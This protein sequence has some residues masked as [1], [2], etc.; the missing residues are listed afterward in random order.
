MP[1]SAAGIVTGT[2]RAPLVVRG[3]KG[4]TGP[5]RRRSFDWAPGIDYQPGDLAVHAGVL[6]RCNTSHTSA[7]TFTPTYFDAL[8]G[9]AGPGG[10]SL[11]PAT[12]PF[13]IGA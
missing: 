4:D 3:P 2:P 8:T 12:I 13:T 6:Y 7:A 11:I 5:T 1:I 10:G 9:T